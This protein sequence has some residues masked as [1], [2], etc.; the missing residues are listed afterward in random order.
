MQDLLN[1]LT[2]AVSDMEFVW[3]DAAFERRVFLE[4]RTRGQCN[5]FIVPSQNQLFYLLLLTAGLDFSTTAPVRERI[6]TLHTT[7]IH[8]PDCDIHHPSASWSPT[9]ETVVLNTHPLALCAQHTTS[10][11]II[12]KRL[13]K[14]S[15]QS[16]YHPSLSKIQFHIRLYRSQVSRSV[17]N[18]P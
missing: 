8:H 17:Q 4:H 14:T 11:W 5:K 9:L 18:N 3:Y 15:I 7:S 12:S 16:S 10:S 2:R 1:C 6:K 13:L